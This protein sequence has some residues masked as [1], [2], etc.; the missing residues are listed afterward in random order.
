M[1][2]KTEGCGDGGRREVGGEEWREGGKEDGREGGR[3]AGREGKKERR[4]DAEAVGDGNIRL[5][6][7]YCKEL[8]EIIL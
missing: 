2:G 1:G 7:P 3:E 5:L 4:R 6:K 8:H